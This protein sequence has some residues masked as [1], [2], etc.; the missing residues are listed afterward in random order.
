L[1]NLVPDLEMETSK[2]HDG[3]MTHSP[4][5]VCMHVLGQVRL[6]VRVMREAIALL[7]AGFSVSIIDVEAKGSQTVEE[8]IHGVCVKHIV[9]PAWFVPAH[10]KP[11]FLVKYMLMIISGIFRLVR[12]PVDVYHAQD[13]RAL[14]ACYIAA[15]IRRKPLVFDAHELPLSDA[16]LRR[17]RGLH[18]LSTWFLASVLPRC[19]GVITVSSPI[20]QEI[21]KLYRV[22][23]VSLVRNV[24]VYQSVAKSNK[25][26]QYLGL[27]PDVR[28]ALYQGGMQPNRGLDRLVRAAP[29]LGPN[30][31]I[32]LLGPTTK[33][34]RSQLEAL[35]LS[36]GVAN[37]VKLLPPVP[38]EE[39]LEWTASA[40]I[41]L[42]VYSPDDSLNV[43]MC[44]P[45]KLFE[46][47]MAGIPVLA[48]ELEAVKEVIKTHDVGQV[49][50]SLEPVEVG[51]EI[52]AMLADNAALARMSRHALEAARYE[53]CWELEKQRLIQFY[54][55]ILKMRNA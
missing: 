51:A 9:R 32:V 8:H 35:I 10:F 31:L 21:G 20:A 23:E 29:F 25:L 28:I 16:V 44:L 55:K 17:W 54:Q 27:G 36:E 33:E 47:L 15:L 4:V 30:I 11:W 38:Y 7:E 3:A 43:K 1:K 19:A 37:C 50:S 48:S 42:I 12:S 52:T 5:R 39:L 26:R 13:Q 49:V 6:D 40:D 53:F 14:P 24:P 41:G 18:A 46:Y 45:N 2:I 34:T 22:S